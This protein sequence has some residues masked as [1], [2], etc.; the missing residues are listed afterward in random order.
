MTKAVWDLMTSSLAA[1]ARDRIL[2]RLSSE[3]RL[4]T[5][6]KSPMILVQMVQLFLLPP[7]QVLSSDQT[8]HT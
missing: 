2:E 8:A 5:D 7:K 6:W 1:V 4:S 3:E